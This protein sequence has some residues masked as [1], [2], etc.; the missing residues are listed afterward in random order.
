[1]KTTIRPTPIILFL[2]IVAIIFF[3]I[4]SSQYGL[5]WTIVFISMS[6]IYLIY[7]LFYLPITLNDEHITFRK[8]RLKDGGTF[9]GKNVIKI[10]EI[11]SADITFHIE[12]G[13]GIALFYKIIL[14]RNDDEIKITMLGFTKKSVSKVLRLIKEKNP[15]V[16]YSTNVENFL[17]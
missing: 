14:L 4:L 10:N 15:N 9:F 6:I 5:A 2:W 3:I 13:Q 11:L 8:R 12:G 7:Y 16:V 1:M 17:T